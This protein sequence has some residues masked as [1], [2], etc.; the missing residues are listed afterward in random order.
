M[1]P[2]LGAHRVDLV[3]GNALRQHGIQV[4]RRADRLRRAGAVA[5]DH[6]DAGDAGLAQQPDRARRIRTKFVGEQQGAD[7]PPLDR[8]EHDERR[9]PRGAPDR[10]DSP[11]RELRAC[12][13]ELP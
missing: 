11:F 1:Q 2:L 6:D 9:P 8:D 3:G 10:P 7:R 13:D 5:G 12:Q 4:E